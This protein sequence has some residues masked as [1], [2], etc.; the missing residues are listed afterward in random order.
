MT[1]WI[2]GNESTIMGLDAVIFRVDYSV[3]KTLYWLIIF[4][5]TL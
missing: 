4:T 3:D 5:L 1:I 2:K